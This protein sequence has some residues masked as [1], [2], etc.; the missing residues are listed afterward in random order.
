MQAGRWCAP[1]ISLLQTSLRWETFQ[2]CAAC[3]SILQA[4][5]LRAGHN[6]GCLQ[7]FDELL[8]VKSGGRIMYHGKVGRNAASLVEF[9]KARILHLPKSPSSSSVCIPLGVETGVGMC[10]QSQARCRWCQARTQRRGY[11]KRRRR[12]RNASWPST[13]QMC[14]C[15]ASAAGTP[16]FTGGYTVRMTENA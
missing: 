3:S 6:C 9:F 8:L 2:S 5:C 1:F 13:S 4:M 15:K 11:F 10:R 12:R 16:H 14:T 7:A